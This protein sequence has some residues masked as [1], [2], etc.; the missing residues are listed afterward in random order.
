MFLR[1]T[2]SWA[3][4]TR[5]QE[6]VMTAEFSGPGPNTFS[7]FQG[8]HDGLYPARRETFVFSLLGQAAIVA[9]LIYFTSCVIR[10][11]PVIGRNLPK[12]NE[13]LLVFSGHNGGGGGDHD[14]L[15]ASR[16]NLPKASLDPQLA[17]P[18]VIVPKEPPKLAVPETVQVAPDIQLP[19]GGQVADPMSQFSRVL[20]GGPGGPGGIG[21]GCCDGVGPST[22]PGFGPG[23]AGIYPAGKMGV[24]VPQAIF[25]PEPSFSDEARKAKA[26]GI[27]MLVLVVGKDGRTSDIHVRQSLGMGLDEKAIEAVSRWRFRPA[28]LNGQ[29]VATQ[30]AVQVDFRLY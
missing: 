24:T 29:A 6:R 11:T 19:R 18:T 17:P 20:S 3:A 10:S 26:Q 2:A 13:L 1:L 15:P 21:T 8:Q 4:T 28:T 14:L 30:I 22:G 23:P 5:R 9:V 7:I 25:S 27:V 16:G 12:A